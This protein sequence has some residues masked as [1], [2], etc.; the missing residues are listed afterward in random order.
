MSETFKLISIME[1]NEI[2]AEDDFESE[3]FI[4]EYL[5][6]CAVHRK[7]YANG[8][9]CRMDNKIP[10]KKKVQIHILIQED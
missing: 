2:F 9:D 7:A 4:D 5:I 6:S 8:K 10:I 3:N 1:F